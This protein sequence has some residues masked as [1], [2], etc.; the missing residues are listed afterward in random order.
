[1]ALAVATGYPVLADPLSG[2]RRGP[3]W[4]P[5]VLD[6]YDAFLRDEAFAAAHAPDLVLRFGAMPTAK[7]VLQ[8]LQR[9]PGAR[10]IVVDEAGWNEPTQ[11]ASGLIHADPAA[12]CAAR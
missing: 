2:V 7:P 5:L 9:Y 1:M 4:S 10:Q 11:L 12:L 3:H 8:F 6:A